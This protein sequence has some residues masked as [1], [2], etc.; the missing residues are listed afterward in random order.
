MLRVSIE[1]S[2]RVAEVVGE[3]SLSENVNVEEGVG[4]GVMVVLN[5]TVR[6]AVRVRVILSVPARVMD[7]ELSSDLEIVTMRVSVND[8]T[9][10]LVEVNEAVFPDSVRY[11]VD[12]RETDLLDDVDAVRVS[13]N[14]EVTLT[15]S[16]SVDV[17]VIVTERIR[18]AENDSDIQHV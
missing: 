2:D 5:E 17:S 14:V 3:L 4:G 11:G 1:L 12:E 13:S 10:V 18:D 9:G 15:A 16:V 8:G 6:D 7:I